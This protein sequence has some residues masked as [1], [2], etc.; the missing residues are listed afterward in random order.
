MGGLADRIRCALAN[1]LSNDHAI[2][3]MGELAKL[4]REVGLEPGSGGG[5]V[6]FAG[7][8]PIVGSPVPFKAVIG[9][10]AL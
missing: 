4:L 3:S 5:A 8:D 10:S 6:T 2:D 7:R 9:W 1:P